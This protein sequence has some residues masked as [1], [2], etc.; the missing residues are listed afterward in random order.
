MTEFTPSVPPPHE[1]RDCHRPAPRYVVNTQEPRRSP[2]RFHVAFSD[3]EAALREARICAEARAGFFCHR[4]EFVELWEEK[5]GR[6]RLLCT[7]QFGRLINVDR[8]VPA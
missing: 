7:W 5:D 2:M 6:K 1:D 3:R 8:R 4:Y